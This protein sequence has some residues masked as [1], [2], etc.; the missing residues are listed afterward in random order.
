M[1]LKLQPGPPLPSST[2]MWLWLWPQP[3]QQGG[4]S[5]LPGAGRSAG[6]PQCAGRRRAKT[7]ILKMGINSPGRS[8]RQSA[9][10]PPDPSPSPGT[11]EARPR[12]LAGLSK[13]GEVNKLDKL[14]N[15][16]NQKDERCPP[17]GPVG[18]GNMLKMAVPHMILG[19][20]SVSQGKI[21]GPSSGQGPG[22]ENW[23]IK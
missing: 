10:N 5:K 16:E 12:R 15:L 20:S 6:N 3:P 18:P 8:R 22:P 7:S 13:M 21:S 1:C 9:G 17:L 14:K 11:S 19:V 4:A 2:E 23:K